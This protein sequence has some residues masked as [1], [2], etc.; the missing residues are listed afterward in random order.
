MAE[1]LY[2]PAGFYRRPE[3]PLGHFRTSSAVPAFAAAV[4]RLA[5]EVD[6]MLGEPD[7]F[8][9][10]DLGA[11]RGEL[12]AAVL[13]GGV[14]P[15]WRLSAVELADRP[16]GLAGRGGLGRVASGR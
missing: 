13:A 6:R 5:L 4:R 16:P 2:G 11:G 9:L 8:D 10:V 15:R 1:A 12:L 3:G 14:P 7:P